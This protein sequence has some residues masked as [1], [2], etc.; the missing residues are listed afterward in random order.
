LR[1]SY[2]LLVSDIADR[3]QNEHHAAEP[4]TTSRH[5]DI[6]HAREKRR[7]DRPKVQQGGE[8]TP[9]DSTRTQTISDRQANGPRYY[10]E[11]SF[12]SLKKDTSSTHN[13][14]DIVEKVTVQ[15]HKMI[16]SHVSKKTR[17][18]KSNNLQNNVSSSS[19]AGTKSNGTRLS[20]F[21]FLLLLLLPLLV[22]MFPSK[23][24]M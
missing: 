11:S 19:Q 13:K 24:N 14:R 18:Q 12:R 10:K 2:S 9:T 23:K 7:H 16:I 8:R 5:Q 1:G 4:D 20:L 3:D 6:S 21:F 22:P 17:P 15:N